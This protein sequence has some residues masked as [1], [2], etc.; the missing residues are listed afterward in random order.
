MMNMAGKIN[1]KEFENL[2]K[3]YAILAQ[4]LDGLWYLE[5]EKKYGFEAAYEIDDAV[6]KRFSR[7]EGQ[8]LKTL[9]GF[10]SPSLEDIE[11]ILSLAN[12]DQSLTTEIIR[13]SED[14]LTIHLLV[15][16]C[17]T[18]VGMNRVGRPDDQVY[19]IC[20]GIGI[21][22]FENLLKAVVPD[23][24]IKCLY[25]PHGVGEEK[26]PDEGKYLCGW[27]FILPGVK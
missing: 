27:E 10:E 1:E 23:A 7:K 24:E 6:W 15:P 17:K 2:S 14:P 20:K 13:K 9:L 16:E 3:H 11:K 22:F 21:T 19:K 25:C 8:R 4:I 12:F 5:V 18:Y 26:Q